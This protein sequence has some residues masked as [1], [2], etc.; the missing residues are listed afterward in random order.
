MFVLSVLFSCCPAVHPL[1]FPLSSQEVSFPFLR[2][3]AFKFRF[4]RNIKAQITIFALA[5]AASLVYTSLA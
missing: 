1:N 2:F 3:L 5:L 4:R